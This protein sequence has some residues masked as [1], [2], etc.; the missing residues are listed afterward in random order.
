MSTNCCLL[1]IGRHFVHKLF[2]LLY[3]LRLSVI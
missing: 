3:L 2:S 1:L